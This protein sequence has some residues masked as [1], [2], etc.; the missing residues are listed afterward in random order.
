[1]ARPK[2]WL[3][4]IEQAADWADLSGILDAAQKAFERGKLTRDKAEKVAIRA[5]VR[6][7]QVPRDAQEEALRE[8]RAE[9]KPGDERLQ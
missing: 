2:S 4:A 7:H 6:A 8:I 3:Q 5:A 9:E 1:M